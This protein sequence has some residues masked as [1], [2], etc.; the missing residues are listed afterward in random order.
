MKKVKAINNAVPTALNP[1]HVNPTVERAAVAVLFLCFAVVLFMFTL[2]E[3]YHYDTVLYM[4]TVDTF[5]DTSKLQCFFDARC[6]TGYTLVPL[7]ILIGKLTLPVT[8]A[9]SA[10]FGLFFYYMWIKELAGFRA[11]FVSTLFLFITPA[12]LMTITHLKEDFIGL[13]YLSAALWLSGRGRPSYCKYISG[14]VLGLAILSKDTIT[15]FL[16]FFAFYIY[17][18]MA[19]IKNSWTDIFKTANLKK[20][21]LKVGIIMGAALAVSF[22][23]DSSHFIGLIRKTKSPYDGQF[24]G[25]FSELFPMGVSF[26]RYGVGSFLFICQFIGLAAPFLVKDRAKKLIYLAFAV[27]FLA[28]SDFYCNITVV[29]YRHFLWQGVMSFPIMAAALDEILKRYNIKEPLSNALVYGASIIVSIVLFMSV[30]PALVFHTRY[31]PVADFFKNADI[32]K[33]NAMVLGMDN[34]VFVPYFMGLQCGIHPLNPS[35]AQASEYARGVLS[36]LQSGKTIYLL[37]DFFSYD[38][39]GQL[40][41][42]FSEL[43]TGRVV[44]RNW[45]ADFHAMDYGYSPDTLKD[46]LLRQYPPGTCGITYDK[47]GDDTI[48][49]SRT[50]GVP[51]EIYTY[52]LQC[53]SSVNT[54]NAAVIKGRAFTGLEV[55][56]IMQLLPKSGT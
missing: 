54:M 9:L 53:G 6:A 30:Y 47:T 22:I 34:C 11:A 52:K 51:V 25:V 12:A 8:M 43:F 1:A 50:E 48:S 23:I 19:D 18:N 20:G 7:S 44:Y 40:S 24:L 28:I 10:L 26:W 46:N 31:N 39:D 29:K 55:K 56:G 5:K 45:F 2:K 41:K 36:S 32:A 15:L 35:E 4:K 13:M 16:P 42:E 17:V 37:P 21:L 3:P 38:R 33:D 14:V 49:T 27:Q